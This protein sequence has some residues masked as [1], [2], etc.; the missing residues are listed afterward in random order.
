MKVKQRQEIVRCRYSSRM[1]KSAIEI[2][3]FRV[4]DKSKNIED[5]DILVV[6]GR[7]VGNEKDVAMCQELADALGGRLAFTRPM[8]E[9]GYGDTAHQIG[10]FGRTVRPKLISLPVVYPVLSSLLT[11]SECIVAIN[12]DADAQI[13]NVA[14]YHRR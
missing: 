1:T 9:N 7:G 4:I 5:E 10:L 3:F 8:V 13:F 14:H 12:N 2:L 11:G 6:A